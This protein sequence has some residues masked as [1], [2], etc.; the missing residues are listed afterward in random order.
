[1]LRSSR[2]RSARP[3][4]EPMELDDATWQQLPY[5]GEYENQL[6]TLAK[7]SIVSSNLT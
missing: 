3:N 4:G 1:M 2:T 7:L 6:A 5:R